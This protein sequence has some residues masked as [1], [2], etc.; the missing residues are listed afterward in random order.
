MF[1]YK[2]HIVN[3]SSSGNSVKSNAMHTNIIGS[4]YEEDI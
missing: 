1:K 2:D 4:I 3:G